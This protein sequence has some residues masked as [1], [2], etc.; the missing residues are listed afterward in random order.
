MIS[1]MIQNVRFSKKLEIPNHEYNGHNDN[2][3]Q[4]LRHDSRSSNQ[5][6]D[7]SEFGNDDIKNS[8][9]LITF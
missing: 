2:L 3:I 5:T 7:F 1:F 4:S 9:F 6:V 8:K